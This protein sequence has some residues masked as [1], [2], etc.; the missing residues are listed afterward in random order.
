VCEIHAL[1]PIEEVNEEV[2]HQL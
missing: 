2:D 1:E